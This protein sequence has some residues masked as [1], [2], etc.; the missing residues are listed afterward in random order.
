MATEF[1]NFGNSQTYHFFKWVTHPNALDISKLVKEAFEAV[2]GDEWFQLDCPSQV[3]KRKLAKK[4][5]E[6]LDELAGGWE[7]TEV[8]GWD[9]GNVIAGSE[10]DLFRPI[11]RLAVSEIDVYAVAEA[12]LVQQR[13]WAP[14][15]DIPEA[16]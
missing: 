4:L 16:I 14:D 7:A 5:G 13:R 10:E 8:E 11:L 3:A 12:V 2:E 9:I 1:F 15:T 6:I